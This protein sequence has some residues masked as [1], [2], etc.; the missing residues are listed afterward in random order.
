MGPQL[1]KE[2]SVSELMKMIRQTDVVKAA[3]QY[4][5]EV[6]SG[7]PMKLAGSTV[8]VKLRILQGDGFRFLRLPQ[9]K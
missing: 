2:G 9:P 6:T 3:V 4:Q 8:E 5:G 1:I 7:G